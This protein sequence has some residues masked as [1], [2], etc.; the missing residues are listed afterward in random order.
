MQNKYCR[1]NSVVDSGME[2][3]FSLERACEESLTLEEEKTPIELLFGPIDKKLSLFLFKTNRTNKKFLN[4]ISKSIYIALYILYI[5]SSRNLTELTTVIFSMTICVII[6]ALSSDIIFLKWQRNN[7]ITNFFHQLHSANNGKGVQKYRKSMDVLNRIFGSFTWFII[8]YSVAFDLYLAFGSTPPEIDDEVFKNMMY[9]KELM[10]VDNIIFCYLMI[11]QSLQIHTYCFCIR[12]VTLEINCFISEAIATKCE[13]ES[14]AIDF[15]TRTIER[16][17]KL[18]NAVRVLDKTFK[19]KKTRVLF[20]TNIRQWFIYGPKVH[21]AALL[22]SSHLEQNDLG[23]TLWGFALLSKPLILT[24]EEGT[25]IIQDEKSPIEELFEPVTKIIMF[26]WQKKGSINRYFRLL[27]SANEGKGVQKNRERILKLNTR[28]RWFRN[29]LIVYSIFFIIYFSS[30]IRPYGIDFDKIAGILYFEQLLIIYNLTSGYLL[31]G[32]SIQIHTYCYC[33]RI[34]LCEINHFIQEAIEIQCASEK[35]AIAFFTD[36]IRRNSRLSLSVRHLDDI[37]K[38]F[39]FFEIGMIIP[40]TLFTTFAAI[41]RRHAP[42]IEFLPALILVFLCLALFHIITIHPARLH[43][44]VKK[45]RALFCSNIRQ[46]IPYG[47]SVHTAALVL[48]SHLEQNDVGVTIWGFALLSKPLILTSLSAMMTA[49][50]IFLQFSDC[51]KQIETNFDFQ[52]TTMFEMIDWKRAKQLIRITLFSAM[53]RKASLKRANTLFCQ[54]EEGIEFLS[55][56]KKPIEIE[57]EI[58]EK[59]CLMSWLKREKITKF[60]RLLHS[61]NESKGIIKYRRRMQI[62]NRRFNLTT[63]FIIS[64]SIFFIF[65]FASGVQSTNVDND[66]IFR[67]LY[68]KEL[69]V[70]FHA[71]QMYLFI[72]FSLELHIYAFCIEA[73]IIEIRSFTVESIEVKKIVQ[74]KL[75]RF[76]FSLNR[77]RKTVGFTRVFDTSM[78]SSRN[79]PLSEFIPSLILVA[80]CIIGFYILTVFP[81]RLHTQIK[82]TRTLFCSNIRQWI[83]YG[84]RVNIAALVFAS[85]LE[86]NEIGVTIWGFAILSKPLILTLL[87]AMTTA[88][89]IFLQFSD[90]K[91]QI[92]LGNGNSNFTMI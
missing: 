52:N 64:L 25:E 72:G 8:T 62:M 17:A 58:I 18:S 19:I 34:A 4:R 76:H 53:D 32:W 51:K 85:H 28:M 57:Y 81:A 70:F 73:T 74:T 7:T 26:N 80:L 9:F 60:F 15:F 65:Y 45:T 67:V 13:S 33:I 47:Q 68:Y 40:C 41:M 5:L 54:C 27:Y 86:P 91:R 42:L 83:P 14:E 88:L 39:A 79:A 56:D 36:S 31:I 75:K 82:K 78:T 59:I 3:K 24:C 12:A 11:G 89:A 29:F 44:Q 30:G 46:W 21:T 69:F 49:L 43:N 16:N 23:V 10:I 48:S 90:C 87:S 71:T 55:L 66:A 50:A 92:E 84:Q 20:C 35:E 1:A 37:F 6:T 61:V 38:R 77:L 2:R 63:N 22:L